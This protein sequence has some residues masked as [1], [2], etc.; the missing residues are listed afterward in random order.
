MPESKAAR[1]SSAAKARKRGQTRQRVR[2]AR[3]EQRVQL[4]ETGRNT[5]SQ[6]LVRNKKSQGARGLVMPAIVGVGCWLFA[7]GLTVTS[8]PNRYLLAGMAA[9]IA[10][11][12]SISFFI[13]LRRWQ[14]RR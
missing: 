6:A 10:L 3:E 13:R 2:I 5:R 8:D 12:W 4:E 1:L 14:K 11:M 7:Y 9:L